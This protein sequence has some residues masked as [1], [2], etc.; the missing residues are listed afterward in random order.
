MR[1]VRLA[2]VPAFL[3]AACTTPAPTTEPVP[4]TASSPTATTSTASPEPTTTLADGTPL[5]EGCSGRVRRSQ[6]VAFV[7]GERAWSLDPATGQLACLFALDDPGPFAWGPQGDRVL[8]AGLGVQGVDPDA[9]TLPPIDAEAAA[10]DWG[11][12]IGL[13]IVFAGEQGK[14]EKR[15]VDD[16]SVERLRSLP[17]GAYEQVA[18]HPSGLALGFVLTDGEGESIWIS[19][20]E[21]EEPERLVFSR[22][23]TTFT[24]IAFSPDGQRL[25]W[26]AEHAPGYPVVHW[27]DLADRSG[28]TD[29]WRGPEGTVAD[30]LRLSPDGRLLSVNTGPNCD[31]RQAL[32]VA[33]TTASPALPDEDRPT[34]AIGWLDRSTVLVAAGGCGDTVDLFAAN[35]FDQDAAALVFGVELGAT[36][37]MVRD[38]PT[39]VPVPPD[40]TEAPPGG[41]G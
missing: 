4:S 10:F 27:M 9:P 35:V 12:P 3:A 36:R 30:D 15:F 38:V 8:L 33:G 1:P 5:P 25:W 24:S 22:G 16:G 20:N 34:E 19:T 26:T 39:E 14:P 32:I 18:Y 41:V 40:E 37:T 23:S 2:L 21:G 17:V 6:T 7:A 28:F 31:D 29:T 13:A 11:H